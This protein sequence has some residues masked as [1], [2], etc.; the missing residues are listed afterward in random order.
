MFNFIKCLSL[1]LLALFTSQFA[2]ANSL[3]GIW[4]HDNQQTTI[5]P[6]QGFNMLFC[7]EQGDCAQGILRGSRVVVVPQWNVTG[8][9][10]KS[11]TLI[12]WSNGTQWARY[13]PPNNFNVHHVSRGPSVAGPWL[14]DGRPTSIQLFNDG[15]HFTLINEAGQRSDG[16]I[17]RNGELELPNLHLLGRLHKH[18]SVI[19]WTN[20]TTWYRP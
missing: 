12:V 20:G 9:I 14:H 18:G 5:R 15:M 17:N 1:G 19:K 7:N 2:Y 4:Q 3:A 8:S 11:K 13:T 16:F 6:G 10:N